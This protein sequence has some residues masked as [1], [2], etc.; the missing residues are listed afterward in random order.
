VKNGRGILESDQLLWG[1]PSTK[2]FVEDYSDSALHFK[3]D[4]ANSM[5]KMGNIELKTGPDSEIRTVCSAIN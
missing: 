1:D 2:T 4:F 5:V 3:M